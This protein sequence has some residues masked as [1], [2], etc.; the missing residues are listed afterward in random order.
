MKRKGDVFRER[1]REGERETLTL[2]EK[3]LI[4]VIKTDDWESRLGGRFSCI[5]LYFQI[6]NFSF[7]S[8][9]IMSYDIVELL[10]FD[11]FK[12]EQAIFNLHLRLLVI[13]I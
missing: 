10:S 6:Y 7:F 2:A 9:I 4:E 13:S 3:C 5:C 12:L 8:Y 11:I 1:E